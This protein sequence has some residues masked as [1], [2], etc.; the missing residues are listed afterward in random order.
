MPEMQVAEVAE[1]VEPI[2]EKPRKRLA[3][4]EKISRYDKMLRDLKKAVQKK[5]REEETHAKVALGGLFVVA[6]FPLMDL[7][8][9]AILGGLV[10]M[11]EKI[12][13][14]PV[15]FA[16][17]ESIGNARFRERQ[18]ELEKQKEF[19]KKKSGTNGEAI[20]E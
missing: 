12:A 6:G 14:D 7:N 5:R 1:V 19:R 20:T 13:N 10:E 17:W 15:M 3:P 4:E 16:K 11:H 8:K 9:A 2:E 18:K